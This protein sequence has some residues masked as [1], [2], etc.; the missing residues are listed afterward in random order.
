[1][2]GDEAVRLIKMMGHSG[3][4]PGALPA[5]EVPAA[6]KQLQTAVAA[7]KNAEEAP[8]TDGEEDEKD[9]RVNISVRAWP[10]MEMLAAAARENREVMWYQ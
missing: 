2:L 1:M 10:L 5:D 4:V 8:A 6:L 9:R 3:T 7:E